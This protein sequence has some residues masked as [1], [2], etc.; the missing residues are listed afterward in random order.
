MSLV[1]AQAGAYRRFVRRSTG[2]TAG[3]TSSASARAAGPSRGRSDSRMFR[4]RIQALDRTLSEVKT[5]I[6]STDVV[7]ISVVTDP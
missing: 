5:G 1:N 3:A 6:T 7:I 4:D 2:T